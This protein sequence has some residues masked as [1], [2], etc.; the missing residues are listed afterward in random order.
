LG[1][2]GKR[3]SWVVWPTVIFTLPQFPAV[4][5]GRNLFSTGLRQSLGLRFFGGPPPPHMFRFLMFLDL[6]LHRH[7]PPHCVALFPA[8]PARMRGLFLGKFPGEA[9]Q[10]LFFRKCRAFPSMPHFVDHYTGDLATTV[11]FFFRGFPRFTV[12]RQTTAL[13]LS[14]ERSISSSG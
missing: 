13:M 11:F 9:G 6:L 8:S 14:A 5:L 2:R 3:P 10:D 7:P 12:C 4:P 1:T